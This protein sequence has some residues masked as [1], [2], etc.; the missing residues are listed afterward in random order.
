MSNILENIIADKLKEVA[1]KKQ[2]IPVGAWKMFPQYQEKRRSLKSALLKNTTCIIAEFKRRSPSK[3]IINKTAELIDVVS[4]YNLST[5][6]ISVLT[7]ETYFGGTNDDMLLARQIV[8]TPLLRKDF[9]IDEYQLEEAKAIGAD[10]ILLIAACLTKQ[11]VKSLAQKARSLSLEVLL[12]IHNEQELG[13]IC[14]E[15]DLIGINNRNL[16]TFEVDITTSINLFEKI[17]KD[18]LVIAESGINNIDTIITLRNAGFKGFLIG[19]YFMKQNDPAI[20]FAEFV[21]QLKAR[22]K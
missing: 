11:Q 3:G 5:A 22:I 17:S 13:H 6:G 12:E 7:D 16:K 10:V 1:L 9:I 2:I 19:E 8:S 15:A 4:A 14:D 20:A 18:K 21:Q